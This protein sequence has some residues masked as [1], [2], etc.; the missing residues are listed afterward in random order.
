MN[1]TILDDYQDA[2]RTLKCYSKLAGQPINVIIPEVL[3][4]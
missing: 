4:R 1:I 3:K 2:V